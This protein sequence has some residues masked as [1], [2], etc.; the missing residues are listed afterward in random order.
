MDESHPFNNRTMYGAAKIANEQMLR[1]LHETSDLQYIALRPFNVYGPR[2]DVTGVYTE[3][4]IPWLDALETNKP[5]L[6]FRDGKQSM[7]FVYVEGVA[8]ANLLAAPRSASAET[9]NGGSG[10]PTEPN[11][12]FG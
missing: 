8:R 1:A 2:M 3:G 6:I 5:P 10:D 12:I 9:F 11:G 7:G 4:L